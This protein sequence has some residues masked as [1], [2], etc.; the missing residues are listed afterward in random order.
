MPRS[1]GLCLLLALLPLRAETVLYV[2]VNGRDDASGGAG[3]PLAT[4]GRAIDLARAQRPARVIVRPGTY[5]LER[6]IVLGPEDSGLTTEGEKGAPVVVSGGRAVAG[7]KPWRNGIVRADLSKLALPD[8]EFHE[9]YF[10]GKLMPW[11]RTPNADP[12][13]PRTGGFLQSA[14]VPEAGTK[15]KLVYPAGTLH[16]ERWAHP[17]RAWVMFHDSLNYETQYGPVKSIDPAQRIVEAERGVYVLSKG[18]PFYL[19]GILEELDAPGEWCVD[20]D[21]QTLYFLPPAGNLG[22][23][24]RI[25]VPALANAFVLAGRPAENQWVE[26]VRLAG[27]DIRDCRGRAIQMTGAKACTV[28]R[29]DLRNAEVGVYLG[30]DTH[31]CLV[32]G[33]DITAT[34]GDGVSILGTTQ[35]HNRVTGNLVDNCYI[36]DIG[37]GRIH[38]RCGGVYMHRC[39]RSRVT[40][41]L[42]HDTPRYAI[43]MDV[44]GE[45]EIAW[46]IGHHSNL[47][48][49]DTSIIEAA[50]AMD[51]GLPSDEQ[52]ARN[53]KWN[54]GNAIHHNLIHDSGG[55]GTNA[56][57]VLQTPL[58]SWGIYLD[59]HSSGWQVHDNVIWNTV[60]GAYMVNGGMEN[61]FDN[62]VCLDG[63]EHQAY[64][65]VWTKYETTGNRVLHSIFAWPGQSADAYVVRK[66]EREGYAFDSNLVWAG[67]VK[68]RVGGVSGLSRRDSWAGWQKLGQDA[69]S[70]VA[71][72]QFVDPARRD[73][74]LKPGSPALALGIRSVDLS[75][76]GLYASPDRRTWPRPE[77]PV[78]RDDASYAPVAL[79]AGQPA[80][81]DYEDDALGEPEHG[82]HVGQEGAGT[83]RVTDETAAAGKHSLKFTDAAGLPHGFVPYVTYPL[84]LEEGAL[85]V[86]FDLRWETGALL[87]LDWRDDPYKYNMGPNLTTT[88]D[89]WLS[90]NGKRLLP[91]PAGQWVHV[92]IVCGLGKLAAGRY[93]LTLTL[94]GAAPQRIADLACSHQFDYLDCIVFMAVGDAPGVFYLD[95]LQF[96]P[97]PAEK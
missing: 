17:E 18:N 29:C 28:A 85:T 49:L 26:N 43:G 5:Q 2:A 16:P 87:A 79:R 94:P 68:P 58:Y 40:H 53:R 10:N 52:M 69:G 66:S 45:C 90:A 19:C 31:D 4:L 44:G 84:P 82:A 89:G 95:N 32:S 13:H 24:D 92:E 3:H 63:Q 37:W 57:G 12:R 91:L 54:W 51:W 83:V 55:W 36:R 61:V 22:G 30:D 23:I 62:N 50:T 81:R 11:A 97:Q 67:G 6:P 47:V 38:N 7:W 56:Q 42:I 64:L 46:N 71:D 80:L 88:A 39:M 14:G 96:R 21:S 65:S 59:T 77:E 1:A 74:R 72:P 41:N 48:T 93:A 25:V 73:Y 8:L 20:P 33:C 15:T 27:L 78:V 60:L 70:L 35:D 34:Q 76:A 9:L 75:A 86:A